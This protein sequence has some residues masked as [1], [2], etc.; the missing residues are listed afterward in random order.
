M[1][2]TALLGR[3]SAGKTTFTCMCYSVADTLP[4]STTFQPEITDETDILKILDDFISEKL[5]PPETPRR[6]WNLT[7]IPV[8]S[9]LYD[10][11]ILYVDCAGDIQMEALK[12]IYDNIEKKGRKGSLKLILSN[13]SA[14]EKN[15]ELN[16]FVDSFILKKSFSRSQAK[17][18]G[19]IKADIKVKVKI[20]FVKSIFDA[21]RLIVLVDGSEL[22]NWQEGGTEGLYESL[23]IFTKIIEEIKFSKVAVVIS[24]GHLFGVNKDNYKSRLEF[25]ERE[26][27]KKYPGTKS[28]INA[29]FNRIK[30]FCVG[31]PSAGYKCE[32][33]KRFYPRESYYIER[34]WCCDIP[35][36]ET[37][38]DINEIFGVEQIMNW[39]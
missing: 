6:I 1:G 27:L 22:R 15:E 8:V 2:T 28:L 29:R 11:E 5:L 20:A 36:R 9:R 35:T 31:V 7:S 4:W 34:P 3:R 32:I 33:C 12:E 13:I 25:I 17:E 24:K 37:Y 26:Y 19:K 10:E 14:R 39:L 38:T 21:N 18:L 16:D 30:V 23:N